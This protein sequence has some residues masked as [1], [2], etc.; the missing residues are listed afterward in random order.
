M[1]NPAMTL[2]YLI[3]KAGHSRRFDIPSNAT[4]EDGIIAPGVGTSSLRPGRHGA[5]AKLEVKGPIN[6]ENTLL[7][8]ANGAET[9]SPLS[10]PPAV[11]HMTKRQSHAV[12]HCDGNPSMCGGD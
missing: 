8:S 12:G 1:L 2:D 4:I 11:K 10:P 3:R 9:T 6:Y 7:N 5:S